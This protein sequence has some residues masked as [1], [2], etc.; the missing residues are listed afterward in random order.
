VILHFNYEELTALKAGAQAFLDRESPE[1]GSVL[2]PPESRARVEALVPRL[3]G[4]LSLSS[5]EE[6]RQVKAAVDSIVRCLRVEMETTVVTTHAADEIAVAAYFDFAHG[7]TV[8]HR[9]GEMAAEMEAL[10]ELVTGG[11]ATTET[12]RTFHFPD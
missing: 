4:D 7:F 1:H 8:S 6:L 10:I 11:E 2:A 5:L 12:A 9:I 3:Q